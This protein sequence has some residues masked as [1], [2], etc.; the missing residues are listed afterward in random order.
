MKGIT[1]AIISP[2]YLGS[3]YIQ[4][5]FTG[6]LCPYCETPMSGAAHRPTREHVKARSAGGT[7][8]TCIIVCSSCNADK[9]NMTLAEFA[10]WLY[11]RSDPRADTVRKLKMELA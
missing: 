2:K 4:A 9:N 10:H 8:E 1:M 6:R 5:E 7:L 3:N 11:Q